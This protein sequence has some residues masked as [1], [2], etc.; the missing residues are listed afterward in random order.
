MLRQHK[1]PKVLQVIT[2]SEVGGAQQVLLQLVR[3]L[4]R[5]YSITVA[6]GPGEYVPQRL[7]EDCPGVV[8]VAVPSFRRDIEPGADLATFRFLH[9]LMRQEQ[10]DIV[11][12]HSTKAGVLGRLA[13]M[14]ARVPK[15]V[16]H[17]H[18]WAFT[19]GVAPKRRA[20]YAGIE[21][22]LARTTSQIVC[23]SQYDRQLALR[24]QVG[25]PDQLCVIHNGVP[26]ERY[27][28]APVEVRR[29]WRQ[30]MGLDG[31]VVV[32]MVGR[33]AAPKEPLTLL[34]AAKQLPRELQG[35]LAIVFIGDG[36]LRPELEREAAASAPL[37][38]R[39]LGNRDDVPMILGRADIGAL[40]SRWEGLPLAVMEYMAASLPVVVSQV[41]GVPELVAQ[42]QEGFLVPR[43]RDD[44]LREALVRLT[45]DHQ[46]RARMGQAARRRAK[47]QFSVAHMTEQV[48]QLYAGLLAG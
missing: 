6:C 35:R 33:L 16:F 38:V 26:A 48:Q 1:V 20:L 14:T 21:R 4:S 34:R 7:Q 43:G 39:C 9:R 42:E 11:H 45:S 2:L 37:A 19:E 17:V 22:V 12:C 32:C 36:P 29:V 31:R 15:R 40:L 25:R 30:A 47:Q 27:H 10:F 41:G 24:L 5:H 8:V 44:V 28:V 3:D 18:G 46:L 23:V 13:A